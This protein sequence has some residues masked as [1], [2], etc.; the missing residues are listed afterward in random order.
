METRTLQHVKYLCDE[1]GARPLGSAANRAAEAYVE[2]VL[3]KA[4]LK[5]ERQDFP[6]P[7]WVDENTVLELDGQ[8]LLAAAN[9]FSLPCDVAAPAV[10]AGTLGELESAALTG[11]I[12]ILY[13]DLTKGHGLSCRRAY[14]FPERDGQIMD[15]LVGKAPVA[16]L[17]VHNTIGAVARLLRDWEFP[18]PSANQPG[19]RE[20]A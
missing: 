10:A 12:A 8:R 18:I 17:T 15:T 5:V 19:S 20:G 4:G 7:D 9:A 11:R 16:V 3:R 14:Y 13:G 1:I 6:C 2:L